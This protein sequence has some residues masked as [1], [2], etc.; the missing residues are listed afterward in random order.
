MEIG[1]P[2]SG[3]RALHR[4]AFAALAALA[5]PAVVLAASPGGAADAPPAP[6]G[7]PGTFGPSTVIPPGEAGAKAVLETSPR[8]HEWADVAGG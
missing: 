8:H 6:F 4:K 3:M 2:L 7:S 1:K 5:L